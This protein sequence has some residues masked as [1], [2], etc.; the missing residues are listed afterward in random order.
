MKNIALTGLARSGK[1]TIAARLVQEH[2]YVR[3]AFAD[4]LKEAAL[5]ANP[6]IDHVHMGGGTYLPVTLYEIVAADGWERAK[7][8]YPEVRRF[9]QD[10]GQT[11][12]DIQPMFW[13]NTAGDAVRAAWEA[14]RPVVMTDVRYVNEARFLSVQGFDLVRVIRPGLTPGG[15]QSEREM[16]SYETDRTVVNDGSLSDLAALADALTM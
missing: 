11:V 6:I 7:D 9:L 2:G 10:Y 5:K 1:D 12:R 8:D 16:A 4:R 15:H 14:G 13:I 3:V